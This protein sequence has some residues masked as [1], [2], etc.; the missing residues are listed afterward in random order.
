MSK[1]LYIDNTTSYD[2]IVNHQEDH[3]YINTHEDRGRFTYVV[4][5]EYERPSDVSSPKHGDIFYNGRKITYIND[6]D[7]YDVITDGFD[8]FIGYV[9]EAGGLD[10]ARSYIHI[11]EDN[12]YR[13]ENNRYDIFNLSESLD[14]SYYFWT[15]ISDYVVTETKGW[16]YTITPETDVISVKN[17]KIISDINIV[18]S[19]TIWLSYE[20]NIIETNNYDTTQEPRIIECRNNAYLNVYCAAE[21]DNLEF[22]NMPDEFSVGNIYTPII[23]YTPLDAEQREYNFTCTQ[24]N[25]NDIIEILNSYT[26][27]FKCIRPGSTT[28]TVEDVESHK[29]WSKDISVKKLNPF[30]GVSAYFTTYLWNEVNYNETCCYAHYN[31]YDYIPNTEF[32]YC[33]KKNDIILT[34]TYT[35]IKSPTITQNDFGVA[36]NIII[37]FTLDDS[38][39]MD[40]LNTSAIQ[41]WNVET[42]PV[43]SLLIVDD[44]MIY[45]TDNNTVQFVVAASSR[46]DNDP[47]IDSNFLYSSLNSLYGFNVYD[48]TSNDRYT[49][50]YVI[51][52]VKENFTL[53]S[54]DV[55]QVR[56]LNKTRVSCDKVLNYKAV[57]KIVKGEL[58]PARPVEPYNPSQPLTPVGH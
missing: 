47:I 11:H 3:K 27:T 42:K 55:I 57:D 20:Y 7:N 21:P 22:F 44:S 51:A 46:S 18:S 14:V 52:S 4:F 15:N 41:L 54:D 28:I 6:I 19:Y 13:N 35:N 32:S 17:G 49:F 48:I 43:G 30:L 29:T 10:F 8:N 36:N 24:D 33:W 26:G 2:Y 56:S 58:K 5:S 9:N 38:I 53:T 39:F 1:V 34:G 50:T 31:D 40:K 12:N 16:S 37:K 23:K 45:D 25:G